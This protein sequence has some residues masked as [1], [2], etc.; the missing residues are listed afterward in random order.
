MSLRFRRAIRQH[1]NRLFSLACNMLGSSAEAEDVVQDVL[2]KLWEHL[3]DLSADHVRPWLL[4]VTRNACV[5]LLRR[6]RYQQAFVAEAV[7]SGPRAVETTPM[8]E[9]SN[10]ELGSRLKQAIQD[11]D[12]PFR[13]LVILRELEDCS[14]KEI[15][16]V[17]EL[18]DQ[19]VRVYLHRARR[20]LRH[21]LGS[22]DDE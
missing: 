15:A 14:Y 10:S 7:N 9:L 13:S 20:K 8:M 5:D 21:A 11:L 3:P 19:Q 17:L 1:Q 2:I 16:E 18:S 6:R 12:E 22:N 4:R